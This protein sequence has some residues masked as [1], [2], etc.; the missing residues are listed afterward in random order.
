MRETSSVV[1]G[2]TEMLTSSVIVRSVRQ[3]INPG[4]WA[5]VTTVMFGEG[6]FRS[7]A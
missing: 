6:M 5:D 2:L 3:E 1:V 4:P 7:C